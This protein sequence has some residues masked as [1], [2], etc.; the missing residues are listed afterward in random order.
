[1]IH[2]TASLLTTVAIT[3]VEL[4]KFWSGTL[5]PDRPA[6][7]AQASAAVSGDRH[8]IP[9]ERRSEP[10]LVDTTVLG[11]NSPVRR[12]SRRARNGALVV[13]ELGV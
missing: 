5:T 12:A 1:M 10:T 6:A 4:T 9:R 2:E 8:S 7:V 3:T 13:A 11:R